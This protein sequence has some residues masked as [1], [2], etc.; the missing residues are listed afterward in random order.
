M[1]YKEANVTVSSGRGDSDSSAIDTS[2]VGN[3]SGVT[4]VS[5][6]N[7]VELNRISSGDGGDSA[8]VEVNSTVTSF[9]AL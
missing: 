1:R 7:V 6:E 8:G 5:S 2:D 9:P 4:V 3:V